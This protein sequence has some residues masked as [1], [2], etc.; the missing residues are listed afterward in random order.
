[1]RTVP[2][3]FKRIITLA[4]GV[5]LGVGLALGGLRVATAW[6][7]WPNRELDRAS[8]RVREVFS[9]VNE[10]YVDE[11]SARYADLA[12]AAMHGMADSLDPHSEFLELK[13]NQEFEEEL[14]GQFGGI[15]IQVESRS[16]R[17]LV[18]APM[19]GT[20]G[21]RAGIR[22]GDEIVMIDGK[23]VL[24]GTLIDDVVRRLRGKPKTSVA[25]G[26][27]RT[28]QTEP[29]TLTL[30]REVIKTESVRGTRILGDGIGYI[31]ITEF[32]ESTG[33]QF[34]KALD[35]LL[36]Q[37]INSLVLDLR[38]NPGGLLDAAVQVA[39]LFFKKGEIVVFTQGR[40][41]ENREDF[42]SEIEGEPLSLPV[43]ILING[44]SASAAEVV[45]GAM[46][47]TGRAV[48]V[49]ERSFGKGSVQSIFP[50]KSGE[51]LRL[52]TARYYTPSGI[53]IHEKGIAPHVEV[54]MTPEEDNQLSIQRSRSDVDSVAEFKDRFGFAPI[55][56]RQLKTAIEVLLGVQLL[57]DR[58]RSTGLRG[59]D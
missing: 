24:P 7:L 48:V 19:A 3:M 43:A 14:T 56:D 12:T 35:G 38:N 34:A 41:P 50:L 17:I 45:T 52:T 11:K 25:V 23:P 6:S 49:G 36:K 30:V 31:E 59:Q 4:A 18:I 58:S 1:M 13:D 15:G 21:D 22:R 5:L 33:D 32:T 40:K 51:G 54:V 8:A 47:D 20:P 16:G 29:I 53:S 44:S 46:K 37:G 57:G 10:N 28:G 27:N 2:M 26:L 39:E 55:E 9:L 42:R